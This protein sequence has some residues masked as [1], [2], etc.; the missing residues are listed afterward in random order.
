MEESDKR[1]R[2]LLIVI[3]AWVALFVVFIMG[4]VVDFSQDVVEERELE[5]VEK[6]YTEKRDEIL[7]IF[8]KD[9]TMTEEDI[10]YELLISCDEERDTVDLPSLT[11]F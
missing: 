4:L 5:V 8:I 2:D 3:G 7:S 11:D 9:V 6:P 1:K 10:L